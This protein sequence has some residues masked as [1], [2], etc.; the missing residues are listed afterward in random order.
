[1]GCG[2][3]LLAGTLEHMLRVARNGVGG[4]SACRPIVT[5]Q[6]ASSVALGESLGPIPTSEMGMIHFLKDFFQANMDT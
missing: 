4:R 6:T 5:L 1:M 2:A 3:K